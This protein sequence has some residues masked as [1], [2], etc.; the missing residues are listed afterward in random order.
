MIEP[1]KCIDDVFRCA[2]IHVNEKLRVR[3]GVMVKVDAII[4]RSFGE[5]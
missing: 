1:K 5:F 4:D 2:N 3:P